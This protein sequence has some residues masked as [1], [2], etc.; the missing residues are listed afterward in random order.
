VNEWARLTERIAGEIV[1]VEPLTTAH[2]DGLF[3]AGQD[4]D[5][6]RYLTAYA[7]PRAAMEAL[8]ARFEGIHR[9]HMKV[10]DGWRDTAW[11]SVIAPEWPDMRATLRRRPARHG[12]ETYVQR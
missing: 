8:P 9:R 10:P 2:E 12:L 3:T 7:R 6:W 1:V 11:Y 5:I 4:R